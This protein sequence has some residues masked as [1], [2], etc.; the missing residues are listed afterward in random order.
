MVL[1]SL[2]LHNMAC[3]ARNHTCKSSLSIIIIVIMTGKEGLP[4]Q[5][6]T[7]VPIISI[8]MSGCSYTQCSWLKGSLY[9]TFL[10]A[11]GVPLA[12]SSATAYLAL[13]LL[14]LDTA[15]VCRMGHRLLCYTLMTESHLPPAQ[16]GAGN[17]TNFVY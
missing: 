7:L 4:Y 12:D 16:F 2:V 11:A 15:L 6:P 10:P 1:N 14:L 8:T 3:A 17:Y 9:F 13:G 5:G